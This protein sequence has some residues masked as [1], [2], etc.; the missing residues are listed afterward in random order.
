MRTAT[1]DGLRQPL[2]YLSGV[3]PKRAEALR[4]CG[5]ATVWD[6]INNFPFRHEDR[7][8][9][10]LVNQLE[11]GTPATAKRCAANAGAARKRLLLLAYAN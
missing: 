2:Q 5:L 11:N 1:A 4:R 9:I 8:A 7:R 10:T 3:G 6:A